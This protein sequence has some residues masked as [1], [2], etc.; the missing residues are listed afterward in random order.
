MRLQPAEVEAIRGAVRA[1]L[2]PGA[3]V[4]LFGSRADDRARGGD[5]DLFIEVEPGRATLD[6]EFALRERL[7]PAV[8]DCRVDI[9]LHERGWPLT[10]I[11]RIARR[12]GVVL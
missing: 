9:L 7:E 4:R 8:E 6:A 3:T 11:G 2:G 1:V 12:D 5:I 10:P